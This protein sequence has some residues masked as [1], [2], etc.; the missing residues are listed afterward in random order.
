MDH[1]YSYY[2]VPF[3][4]PGV[5]VKHDLQSGR[6]IAL[7][8]RNDKEVV[9]QPIDRTPADFSPAALRDLGLR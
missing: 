4:S 6:Y 2:D 1:K 9:Y 3:L 5:E 8:L 7:S